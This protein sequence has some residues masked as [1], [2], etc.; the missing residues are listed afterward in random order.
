MNLQTLV[1]RIPYNSTGYGFIRNALTAG[2]ASATIALPPQS[3]VAAAVNNGVITQGVPLS[4]TQVIAVNNLAGVTSGSTAVTSQLQTQGWYLVLQ[5]ATAAIRQARQSPVI[6]LLY[7]DGGS[8][9]Q[10]NLS[11]ILVF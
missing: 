11:S 3:P 9:Q 1:G 8:V 4:A 5:P 7:M 10:I 2:A 6:I